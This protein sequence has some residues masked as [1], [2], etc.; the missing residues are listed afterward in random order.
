MFD[1]FEGLPAT[2]AASYLRQALQNGAVTHAYLITGPRNSGHDALA[3]RFAAALVAAGDAEQFELACAGAHPDVHV[4]TPGSQ[5]GYLVAQVRDAVH[6]ATLAPVRSKSK[7]Y[8][9]H[10]ADKM[11]GAPANAFLK[12]L[13]EP[14]ASVHIILLAATE[15]GVLQ[16]L[17]S[18]CQVLTVPLVDPYGVAQQDEQTAAMTH[19][20]ERIAAGMGN[21]ELLDT[22]K[23]LSELAQAD[24]QEAKEEHAQEQAE[25]ADYLTAGARKDLEQAHK[26]EESMQQRAALMAQLDT[27]QAWL[28]DCLMIKSGAASLAQGHGNAQVEQASFG[29]D[30]GAPATGAFTDP[31]KQQLA[32]QAT[33]AGLLS[34]I[35][36]AENAR[37]RISSNVNPML[38]LEATLIEIREAL[39]PR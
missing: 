4:M 30:L 37:A 1:P 33:I 13:E 35:E 8:I 23:R 39:C 26:R 31:V 20:M 5:V 28:R 11:N 12:T 22:A 10:D 14:P 25:V 17:R 2:P 21:C 18:R 38:A 34:A 7:V 19:A 9:V 32:Q 27:A 24:V 15:G 3:L 6:D 36:A 29:L 16:T